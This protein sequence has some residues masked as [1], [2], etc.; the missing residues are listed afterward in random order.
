ML[1]RPNAPPLH[2][3][4]TP[5]QTACMRRRG[6]EQSTRTKNPRDLAQQRLRIDQMLQQLRR[7]NDV[8]T[9]RRKRR[10]LKF[11]FKD[12]ET[13]LADVFDGARG[14]VEPL[15]VPTILPR[16]LKQ[17]ARSTSDVQQTIVI[18]VRSKL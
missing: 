15:R 13:Q 3:Q 11:A 6:P 4:H 2:P 18:A 7:S 17:I 10:V 14:D 16:R 1:G 5:R 12:L 9:F 8:E